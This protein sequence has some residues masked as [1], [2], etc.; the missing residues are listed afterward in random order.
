DLLPGLTYL[1]LT[2]TWAWGA[3]FIPTV[4]LGKNSNDYRLG[5][6]YRLSAWAGWKLTDWMSLSGRI[7][8]QIWDNIIGADPQLDPMDSPTMDPNLQGG[9]RIDLLFGINFYV[10][11]GFFKGHR[12][13]V[14]A[15]AP[16]YQFLNGPQL[17]TEW[18]VRAGWQWTF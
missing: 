4:R 12:F 3:E 10:P 13:A 2:D 1:G 16:V 14:E 15:G 11:R 18:F 8:G 5:N 6:R 7:D 17:Q 9:K